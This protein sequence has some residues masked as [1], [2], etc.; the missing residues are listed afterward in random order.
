MS[1]LLCAGEGASA[2]RAGAGAQLARA[3]LEHGIARSAPGGSGLLILAEPPFEPTLAGNLAR[4]RGFEAV[5]RRAERLRRKA[6]TRMKAPR[7]DSVLIAPELLASPK[8]LG[9]VLA[10]I[11]AGAP[12]ARIEAA[13]LHREP[14]SHELE[15]RSLVTGPGAYLR[16]CARA[17][18]VIGG[19][20]LEALDRCAAGLAQVL[21]P[22]SPAQARLAAELDRAGAGMKLNAGDDVAAALERVLRDLAMMPAM[23]RL[24][25]ECALDLADCVDPDE[26]FEAIAALAGAQIENPSTMSGLRGSA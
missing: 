9:A 22:A 3:L 25:S 1:F 16:A 11:R 17:D 19:A 13:R 2:D 5:Q 21:V 7:L 12:H 20:G 4:S 6:R 10:G 18:L 15:T 8:T 24:M 23:L 26:T 14:V